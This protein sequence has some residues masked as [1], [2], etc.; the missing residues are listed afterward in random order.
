MNEQ[1]EVVE[2]ALRYPYEVPSHSFV[3]VGE[4]AVDTAEA[5]VG[6]DA[7]TPLL[8]YGSNASPGVLARKLGTTPDPVPVLRATLGD[9]DV[10]YSAH[11]SPYGLVPATLQRSLGTAVGVSVVFLTP[12]QLRRLSQTEPNYTLESLPGLDCRLL[13]GESYENAHAYLSRHGCLAVDGGEIAL[14]AVEARGR[15][16]PAMSE[17]EALALARDALAP[18]QSLEQFIVSSVEDSELRRRRTQALR[19]SSRELDR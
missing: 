12:E 18:G 9:F 14:A 8:A 13:S 3:L 6:L 1:S 17:P 19:S 10:V 2:R 15:R 4:R 5:E 11:I 16:F 7:R